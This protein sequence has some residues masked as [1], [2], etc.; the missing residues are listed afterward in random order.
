M[1]SDVP[2]A[3]PVVAVIVTVPSPTPLTSPDA[4]TRATEAGDTTTERADCI[5]VTAASPDAEPAVAVT[6][7]APLPAAVTSPTESTAATI[8][9]ALDHATGSS[10]ITRPA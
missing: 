6:T 10:S 3:L 4:P 2:T 7:V 1:I 5:T 9:S 8:V